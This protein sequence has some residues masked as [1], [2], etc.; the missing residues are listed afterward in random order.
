MTTA[1]NKMRIEENQILFY[2]WKIIFLVNAKGKPNIIYWFQSFNNLINFIFINHFFSSQKH[3]Q[4]TSVVTVAIFI[5]S[6]QHFDF[7]ESALIQKNYSF[8]IRNNLLFLS[9]RQSLTER[10]TCNKIHNLYLKQK[11]SGHRLN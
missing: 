1:K 8:T 10:S 2:E 11:Q 4:S 7:L 9:K 6:R 5:S 3:L